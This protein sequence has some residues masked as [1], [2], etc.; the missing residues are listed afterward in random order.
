M[1]SLPQYAKKKKK[2]GSFPQF[3]SSHLLH[4][5][6]LRSMESESYTYNPSDWYQAIGSL[7]GRLQ[8]GGPYGRYESDVGLNRSFSSDGEACIMVVEVPGIE[9]EDISIKLEDR[10]ISVSTP[11]GN[12]LESMGARINPNAVTAKLRNGVLTVRIPSRSSPA[13]EVKIDID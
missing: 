4:L 8:V 7:L 5:N 2:R 13:V 12:F 10:Q 9:P 3:S 11:R 1:S 6:V